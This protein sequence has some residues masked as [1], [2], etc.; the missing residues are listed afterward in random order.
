MTVIELDRAPQRLRGILS[1]FCLEIRGGLFVGRIDARMRELLW[2]KV[3][4]L[5]GRGMNGV[6]VWRERNEQGYAFRT[7][8][9]NRREPVLYDGLWLVAESPQQQ[10]DDEDDSC[11]DRTD[12]RTD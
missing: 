6:M 1:R 3:A 8:G 4:Q 9:K 11:T 2:E 12:F 5:A 7:I 10:E